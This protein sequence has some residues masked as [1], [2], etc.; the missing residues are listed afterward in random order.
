MRILF[1]ALVL[2][3]ASRTAAAQTPAQPLSFEVASVK[4]AS[5]PIETKDDY[6]AGYNAGMRGAL[7]AQGMR[8]SGQRV[9]VTD[10]SLK[11]LI[12]LAYQVKEYQIS[13]PAW[14]TAEKYEIVANM[15]P[16]ATHSQAPEMLRTLLESRFHLQL[17][18]ETKKM[19]VYA[20]VAVKG[21]PKLTPATGPAN[22]IRA[23]GNVWTN[24][25]VG[26]LRSKSSS[27]SAFADLLT[28]VADR[29][30]I[31]GTG[32]TG[33]FDFDVAYSSDLNATPADPA[34]SL[35]AALLQLG[36]KLEKRDVPIEILVIDRADRIPTEN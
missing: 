10:N 28:K 17:H 15:P 23:T 3:L 33:L 12:R 20:V 30:V 26:H 34:P 19:P 8:I 1:V 4:P 24:S 14:M 6:S 31:D 16:G 35:S 27:M 11:E 25:G 36:L 2:V 13:A 21:G 29:P 7:A 5:A 22:P 9:N 32:F 18:R